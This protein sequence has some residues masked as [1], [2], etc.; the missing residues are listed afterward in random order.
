ME[1]YEGIAVQLAATNLHSFQRTVALQ[2]YGRR[3]L[4]LKFMT[5]PLSIVNKAYISC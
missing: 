1:S 4:R 2:R 3:L 5:G